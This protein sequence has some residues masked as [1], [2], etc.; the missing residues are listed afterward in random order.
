MRKVYIFRNEGDWALEGIPLDAGEGMGAWEKFT[1]GL[2]DVFREAFGGEVE[3]VEHHLHDIREKM[4]KRA[5]GPTI[6]ADPC[7]EGDINLGVSRIFLPGGREDTGI[8]GRPGFKTLRE[9][10]ESIPKGEYVLLEDDIFSGGTIQRIINLL[11]EY[12]VRIREIVCGI[13]VGV[14]E[15][16]TKVWA[17]E[18]RT[19]EEVVDLNDPRD[20][21]VGSHGG[22][23]V[24]RHHDGTLSRAP[25][26]L[27]FVDTHKRSS[28]PR[29]KVLW[30]AKEV[31][32]LNKVFWEKFP[33]IT[34]QDADPFFCKHMQ[35]QGYVGTEPLVAV[36]ADM[37]N[38]LDDCS[39]GPEVTIEGQKGVVF[40]DL[41]E[42]LLKENVLTAHKRH[43]RESVEK[44][45]KGGW[46][47]GL[48]SDSPHRMLEEWGRGHGLQG[49]TI[50]ENGAVI[51]GR[52][53]VDWKPEEARREIEEWAEK[54][55]TP[56]LKTEIVSKEFGGETGLKGPGIAFGVGRIRSCSVFTLDDEGNPNPVIARALG[57]KLRERFGEAVDIAPEHGF[58]AIHAEPDFRKQKGKALR[59]IAWM[60]YLEEKE[61]VMIGN[62][63]SDLVHASALCLSVQV[64]N[65]SEKDRQAADHVTKASYT[66]GVIET[67]DQLS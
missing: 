17:T 16:A 23:L 65:A 40:I 59:K 53:I 13:Q 31:W 12:E 26:I 66:K 60:A 58:V 14:P 36:C 48:C 22:G 47:V 32:G 62:S 21:L 25:Y 11:R 44:A 33:H 27:P 9:Q 15:V 5:N 19:K 50:S 10:A 37:N 1:R 46:S 61:C 63:A 41:N 34:L 49:P 38:V 43:L 6:S 51:N 30:F 24:I 8:G 2:L 3:M 7:V 67:L 4:F 45:E 28:I 55:G 20:F 54:T 52:A 42:T 56:V 18:T 64:Q 29:E 57:T 39:E 35:R